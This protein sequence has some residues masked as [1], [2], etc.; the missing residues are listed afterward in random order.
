MC[1]FPIPISL[2]IRETTA[3]KSQ[4]AM[5]NSDTNEWQLKKEKKNCLMVNRNELLQKTRHVSLQHS[6]DAWAAYCMFF[7]APARD[8]LPI[9][10]AIVK[11]FNK[12][13]GG[14]SNVCK[15]LIAGCSSNLRI[16]T[17][18]SV[19]ACTAYFKNWHRK[20]SDHACQPNILQISSHWPSFNSLFY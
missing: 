8:D 6:S 7:A 3:L 11:K 1:L 5:Q 4:K 17:A 13:F 10:T 15:P 14:I 16:R 19:L 9:L 18:S 12:Q 2:L 20:F